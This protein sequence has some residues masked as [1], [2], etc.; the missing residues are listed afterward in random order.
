MYTFRDTREIM[1]PIAVVTGTHSSG[2]TTVINDYARSATAVFHS[3]LELPYGIRMVEQAVGELTVPVFIVPE[4]ARTYCNL[5]R[6]PGALT[7]PSIYPQIDTKLVGEGM[8]NY[9]AEIARERAVQVGDEKIAALLLDRSPLDTL[10]YAKLIDPTTL[11]KF[12][13]TRYSPR[14]V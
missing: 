12:H 9:A 5:T 13:S 8:L 7:R 2:K 6:N 1:L 3:E 11:P 14:P 4:A 10:S